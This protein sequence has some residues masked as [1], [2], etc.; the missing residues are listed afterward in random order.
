[1]ESSNY[2]GGSKKQT[3]WHR[4]LSKRFNRACYAHDL[5]Y[6]SMQKTRFQADRDFLS[7]MVFL[8]DRNTLVVW[9]FIYWIAVRLFGWYYWGKE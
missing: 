1:M 2:C 8:S 5:D 3:W 6:I 4:L 9:A 7:A